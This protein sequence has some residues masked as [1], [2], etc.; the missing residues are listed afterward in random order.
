MTRAG[1]IQM[2]ERGEEPAAVVCGHA[3][4]AELPAFLGGAFG[5]VMEQLGEQQIAVAGPPF[6]RYR[7]TDG[8]FDVEA[9]FPAA[10]AV[11]PS[12]RVV[13]AILPGGSVARAVHRGDY[14]G[15][16]QT[17]AEIE[18]WLLDQGQVCTGAPWESYLDGPDVPEP[19]T[20]VSF[21]CAPA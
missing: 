20:Q 17:Y 9:G 13:A 8:G 12:G 3:T 10:A 5:E 18:E 6:A 15:V 14:S 2:V 16:G 1:T 4:A 7:P 19:R 11:S 21:P